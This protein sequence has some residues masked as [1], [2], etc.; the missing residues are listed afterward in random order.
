V[1]LVNPRRW[2]LAFLIAAVLTIHAAAP[3]WADIAPQAPNQQ[4]DSQI[5]ALIETL[6]DDD[7]RGRLVV[8][9]RVLLNAANAGTTQDT[10]KQAGFL[11]DLSQRVGQIGQNIVAAATT[12]LD[13]PA[14]LSWLR[15]SF[16]DPARRNDLFAIIAHIVGFLAA[17]LL[18][19]AGLRM[20][21]HGPRSR[22]E[23]R[24]D[25]GLGATLVFL[26]ARTILD[27]AP[28]AGF[29]AA[30]YGAVAL[31]DPGAAVRLGA[32]A[33]I[34]ASV[35]AR[36]IIAVARMVVAPR[37][38][39]LRILPLGDV[40]ANYVFIWIRR[41]ANLTIY[42][43]FT[44]QSARLLGLPL[45]AYAMLL[46]LLG[47]AIGA[48]F[49]MLVM[50]NRR[51]VAQWIRGENDAVL[52][53]FRRRFADIWHVLLILYL[54]V[55]FAVWAL[56]IPGGFEFILRASLLSVVIIAA[57]KLI[58][59]AAGQFVARIFRLN[60]DVRSRLPELEAR[61]NRYLPLLEKIGRVLLVLFASLGV[62]QAWGVDVLSWAASERGRSVVGSLTTIVIIVVI[63]FAAWEVVS[64]LIERYLAGREADGGAVARSQRVRTLLPLLRNVFMVALT[65]MAVLTVLSE[66][67]ID[68]GPL[69]AGAGVVG[70]AV[71]FG[72]QTLVK[73]IITGLFILLEDSISVGDVVDV[74]GHSGVVE[75]LTIRTIRL[76]DIRGTVHTVPFS[77]V[78]TVKNLTKDFSY[79]LMEI[80]VAYRENVD[81]VIEVIV[82]VGKNIRSDAAHAD[83]ILEDIQVQGLD[84]FDDSAVVIRARI[85]TK[86]LQ[87]W[88]VRRA[89][90]K[91]LKRRFD[92]LGIEMPFPHQTIYFGEDK[93][94]AAPSAPVRLVREESTKPTDD[95]R[96]HT[97]TRRDSSSQPAS[98]DGFITDATDS[99]DG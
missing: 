74:A 4:T 33:L 6:E 51:P 93:S 49:V 59:I 84:R 23:A 36:A 60:E 31:M 43:A 5:R 68:I 56:E 63:A 40:A 61:V 15:D 39:S 45:P 8:D 52:S 58:S 90:N 25:D 13:A 3:A 11:D 42:G 50:Q 82:D 95:S 96:A 2:L 79:A 21:L 87:Q 44:V 97:L 89:F 18:V 94:G 47:L 72:A 75:I 85:K 76:R 9:L 66:L 57:A 88:S 71:G 12:V 86:P 1:A 92:E 14:I 30:A 91:A 62:L 20:A 54:V 32:L 19:E 41:L 24:S 67:G 53:S 81:D 99:E 35:L 34:N 64:A 70:L 17:G 55:S 78:S 48:L 29:A 10:P 7:R 37:V 38:A 65:V 27:L 22:V 83:N 16:G 98:D 73:D 80:G 77:E 69:L 46:K 26:L 28:I